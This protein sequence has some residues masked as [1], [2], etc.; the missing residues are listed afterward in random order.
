MKI[1][2]FTSTGNSLDIAKHF[3]A[4]LYS[5]P[6]LLNNDNLSFEDDKIG[7]IFP[8]YAASVPYLVSQFMKKASFKADYVF[9]IA[10]CGGSVG[11][12]LTQFSD[13]ALKKGLVVN[14]ANSVFTVDNYLRFFEMSKQIKTTDMA[15]VEFDI[16]RIVSDINSNVNKFPHSNLLIKKLSSFAGVAYNKFGKDVT[17]TYTIESNCTLC[18]TCTKVCP[19]KNITVNERVSFKK[20]CVGCFACTHNCPSNSIRF[21]AERSKVRYRH[22]QVSLSEIIKSNN[23]QQ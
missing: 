18:G 5:I 21:K 20:E 8:T 12:C 6:Q 4:E 14:Y 10:T 3:D 1:F 23:L 22:P 17:N 13:M 16:A 2:Y 19:T 15:K 11:G 7:F 9:V